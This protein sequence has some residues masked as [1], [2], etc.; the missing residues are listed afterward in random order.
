MLTT[1]LQ[2]QYTQHLDWCW[3]H[4]D[5]LITIQP[6]DLFWQDIEPSQAT[7]MALARC[8]LGKFLGVVCHCFPL[9]TYYPIKTKSG[10]RHTPE[11]VSSQLPAPHAL[12]RDK[13]PALTEHRDVGPKLGCTKSSPAVRR[14]P[15][16]W[17]LSPQPSRYKLSYRDCAAWATHFQIMMKEKQTKC[18]FQSKPYI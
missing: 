18:I 16:Q 14:I 1:V 3:S 2:T 17:T 11:Q 4:I 12:P 8:I 9:V 10:T 6:L 7:G 5:W 13:H 15:F